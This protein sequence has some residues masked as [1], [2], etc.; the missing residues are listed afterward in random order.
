[1]LTDVNG[2]TSE[3]KWAVNNGIIPVNSTTKFGY[4]D[5]VSRIDIV[6][7]LYLFDGLNNTVS[8]MSG[9]TDINNYKKLYI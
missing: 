1:M 5:M 3:I 6:N 2:F 9:N 4:N 8:T 7:S